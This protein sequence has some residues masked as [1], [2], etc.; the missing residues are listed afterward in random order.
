MNDE[1]FMREAIK[2]ARENGHRFGAIIIKDNKIISKSGKRPKNDPKYHAETQAIFNADRVLGKNLSGCILYSTC[3]P[4]VMCFYM[5]WV[6]GVSK[7][8]YGASIKD[9]MAA[10]LSEIDISVKDLNKKS[11]NKIELKDN[12]LKNE[13]LELLNIKNNN[14]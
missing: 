2:D 4:C 8:I 7:I 14:A 10:G 12:F 5:A 13:C 9:S 1:K 3:E 6:T 11:G